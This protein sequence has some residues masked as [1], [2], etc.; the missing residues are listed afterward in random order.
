M[1]VYL[2]SYPGDANCDTYCGQDLPYITYSGIPFCVE[3]ANDADKWMTVNF[4]TGSFVI[5]NTMK[6]TCS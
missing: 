4:T 3:D 5:D 2:E 6:V 1:Q